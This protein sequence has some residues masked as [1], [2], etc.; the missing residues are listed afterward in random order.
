[1]AVF[2]SE[3]RPVGSRLRAAMEIRRTLSS[4]LRTPR[5]HMNVLTR[6]VWPPRIALSNARRALW[7]PRTAISTIRR[8][9]DVW[10]PLLAIA[11]VAK[12]T[13][14][15][16][17][18]TPLIF[19]YLASADSRGSPQDVLWFAL[20]VGGVCFVESINCIHNELM[21]QEE[22]AANQPRR[23]TLIA[24]VGEPTLWLLVV[25]GYAVCVVGIIPIAIFVG[26]DVAALIVGASIAPVLYNSGPRLK[27][28]PVLAELAIG[29]AAFCTYLTGWAFNEPIEDAPA[30]IWLFTYFFA[31]TSFLKDLPDVAGDEL[32]GAPGVFSI[33]RSALR[34]GALVFVYLSPYALVVALV[35]AGS[36]PERMLFLCSLCPVALWLMVIGDRVSS[37]PTMIAAYELAFLYV[38]VFFLAMF[39]LYTPTPPAVIAAAV[40]FA[41]RMTV[42]YLGLAPRFVEP[43]FDW[44]SSFGALVRR[45]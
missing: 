18:A 1:M 8:V 39:I 43:D 16:I 44:S 19:G 41:A 17:W 38:H 30:V 20:V 4:V 7:P 35:V 31:V 5:S 14:W 22:D 10:P 34:R 33:R 23:G 28:R 32:V 40:L 26:L 6:D 11:K 12:V 27:R 15:F 9:R 37:L 2:V 13:F 21:D 24:S 25:F 42:L 45:T 36:L 29:W 3:G